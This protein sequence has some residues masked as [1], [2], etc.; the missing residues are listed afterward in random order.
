MTENAPEQ[1]SILFQLSKPQF[2]TT[3]HPPSPDS[4]PIPTQE[5]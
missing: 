5:R 3:A 1:M 2:V 4:P